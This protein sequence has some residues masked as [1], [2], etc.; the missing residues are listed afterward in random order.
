MFAHTGIRD[1]AALF[2]ATALVWS[3]GCSDTT[4]A[5]PNAGMQEIYYLSDLSGQIRPV[6]GY[7]DSALAKQQAQLTAEQFEIAKQVIREQFASEKL[8]K[9]VLEFLEK[10]AGR[11]YLD[12][13]LEWLRTPLGKK[14]MRAKIATY[15]PVD[16]AEMTSFVEQK[17]ANPPSQKRL[18]L[19]ER[20]DTAGLLSAMAST[21]VLLSAHGAAAMADAVKPEDERLGPEAL[22]KSMNSQSA[23]LEPIFEETS[24]VTSLFTFRD[25]SDEEIEALVVFS[26]SEAGKWY[27]GTTSSVFLKTLWETTTSL[28]DTFIVALPAQP[29]S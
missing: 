20:Y 19:I 2:L 25:F 12:E 13:A 1:F 18:E 7:V 23:L 29:S 14:I 4:P 28:G 6:L 17:Q 9:R 16:P 8:E 15:S 3:Q 22:L 11:E 27:H 5:D 26:E 21:T 24:A 10:R